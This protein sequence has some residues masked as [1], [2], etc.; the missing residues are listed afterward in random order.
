MLWPGI[1][2]LGKELGL[3][4]TNS[5]VVGTLKNC[6]VKMYDG[7]NMKV[8]EIYPPEADDADKE[9]ISGLLK[10]NKVKQHD[11]LNNGVKIIFQEYIRPYSMKKIKNILSVI[12]EYF[13]HK[14][15]DTIPICQK[16]YDQKEAGVYYVGNESNYLCADCLRKFKK[17]L[18][19]E[20]WEYQQLPTNYLKGFIG[21]LLFS[22]PGIIVTVIFFVFLDRLAAI[23]ALIYVVLA[24]KGYKMFKGKVSPIGALITIL[25]GIIMIAI[26]MFVAYSV[27]IFKELKAV[28]FD[29]LMFILGMPEV[30]REL[31]MNI[32]LSYVISGIYIVVQLFQMMKEWKFS[33]TIKEAR[34]I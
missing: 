7:M 10:Q 2:K 5:E 31:L 6:F 24:T 12:V 25:V 9:H 18:D 14:Y 17:D 20:H 29:M 30:G 3:K 16:C 8:L 33:K 32:V 11:W 28:D 15:P 23:S 21:A 26:G 19:N 4:R 1:K 22:I 34:E 13:E 27:L